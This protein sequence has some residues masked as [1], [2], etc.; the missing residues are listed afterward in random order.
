MG[1]NKKMR[2]EVQ[3]GE[4]IEQCLARMKKEGYT[5]VRRTEE[6]IFKEVIRNGEK[7]YEVIDSHIVFHAVKQ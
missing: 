4:T 5:P 1:K 2:F 3:E 6:P 7:D